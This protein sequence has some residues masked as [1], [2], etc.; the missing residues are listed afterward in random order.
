MFIVSRRYETDVNVWL[1]IIRNVAVK[2]NINV[3]DDV[4]RAIALR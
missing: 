3:Y 2:V 1:A 4:Y